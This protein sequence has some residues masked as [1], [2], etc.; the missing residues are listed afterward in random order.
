MTTSVAMDDLNHSTGLQ[1]NSQQPRWLI[2]GTKMGVCLSHL[3]NFK[4]GA[5]Y[6]VIRIFPLSRAGPKTMFLGRIYVY[7]KLKV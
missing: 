3:L 5:Q 7:V 1:C 6:I 2:L 4:C